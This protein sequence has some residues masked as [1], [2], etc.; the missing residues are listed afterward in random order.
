MGNFGSITR[1]VV[2]LL[3]RNGA[4][5]TSGVPGTFNDQPKEPK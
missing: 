1:R 4:P 2:L 3:A 5:S